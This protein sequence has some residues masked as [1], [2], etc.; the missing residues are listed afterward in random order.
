MTTPT[1]TNDLVKR[2]EETVVLGL[3]DAPNPA[4]FRECLDE[5]QRL[6][7][8]IE[9]LTSKVQER[10]LAEIT[11]LGQYTDWQIQAAER[12]AAAFRAGAE[13]MREA[14]AVA[15]RNKDAAEF[16]RQM[17]GLIRAE[18]ILRALPLPD[19]QSSIG[20]AT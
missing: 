6:T 14:A 3:F 19:H 10:A 18:S 12:E 17:A 13:A 11:T 5:I 8:E 1:P 15:V 20:D 2:L 4:S 7:A 16:Y 9:R